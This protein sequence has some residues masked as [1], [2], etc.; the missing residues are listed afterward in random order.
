M[1]RP[2]DWNCRSCQHLNFSWRDTCQR[3]NDT[4]YGESYGSMGYTGPALLPGDWYCSA[5][6][7]GVHNFASRM[8]CFKCGALRNDSGTGYGS[9][10]PCSMDL[11]GRSGWKSGDWI[12]TR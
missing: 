8:I 2:G 6:N 3:C 12:C 9:V 4:R 5:R 10:V 11:I 1:S 7:C